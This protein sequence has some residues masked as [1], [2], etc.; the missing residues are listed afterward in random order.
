MPRRICILIVAAQTGLINIAKQLIFPETA[1]IVKQA[2]Y[3]V[4]KTYF[5]AQI[6]HCNAFCF[7]LPLM[8]YFHKPIKIL[9][10]I[11]YQRNHNHVY[12]CPK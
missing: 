1:H 4:Q 9:F 2:H 5:I 11:V 6:R 10:E 8:E 12:K 7:I 3:K